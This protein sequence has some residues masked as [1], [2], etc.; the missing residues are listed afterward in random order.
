MLGLG[1]IGANNDSTDNNI[2]NVSTE[3]VSVVEEVCD[4]SVYEEEIEGLKQQI[5]ELKQEISNK[6]ITIDT[7]NKEVKIQLKE[8]EELRASINNNNSSSSDTDDS[9]VVTTIEEETEDKVEEVYATFNHSKKYDA[10][11]HNYSE[12]PFIEGKGA[13]KVNFTE[14]MNRRAC[15]CVHQGQFWK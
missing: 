7:L 3:T 11:Y 12:C 1:S 8:K 13:E 6:D 15:K 10:Y 5:E 14:V 9:S 4:H 2:D